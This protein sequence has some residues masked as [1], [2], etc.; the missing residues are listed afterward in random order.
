MYIIN[1][2]LYLYIFLRL[3]SNKNTYSLSSRNMR[4][5]GFVICFTEFKVPFR[6]AWTL[7]NTS[8]LDYI[9]YI[10]Y[11]YVVELKKICS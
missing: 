1:H 8:E 6:S 10:C 5:A 3:K 2:I 9:Y 11:E 4:Y 7:I